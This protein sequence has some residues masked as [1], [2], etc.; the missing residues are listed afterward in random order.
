MLMPILTVMGILGAL[1][2]TNFVSGKR[3]RRRYSSA[4][5]YLYRESRVSLAERQ[6]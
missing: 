3:E 6:Q 4:R 1:G 2:K 5:K